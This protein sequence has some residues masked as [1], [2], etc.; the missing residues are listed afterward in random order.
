MAVTIGLAID[1]KR[2]LAANGLLPPDQEIPLTIGLQRV[3]TTVKALHT[4]VKNTKR[5]DPTSRDSL[6][7]LFSS[8]TASVSDL[9]NQGMLGVKNPEARTR[10]TA[11]LAA[12]QVSFSVIQSVLE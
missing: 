10:L 12:F 1:A 5:L 6:F 8:V 4:Q 3:N 9:N 2:E 11:V 7:R